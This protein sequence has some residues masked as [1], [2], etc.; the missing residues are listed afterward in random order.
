MLSDDSL[1][2]IILAGGFGKRSKDPAK[3]KILQQINN[4]SLLSRHLENISRIGPARVIFVLHHG[5]QAVEEELIRLAPTFSNLEVHTTRDDGKGV[6]PALLEGLK[7]CKKRYMGLVLGDTWIQA[8]LKQMVDSWL[9]SGKSGGIVARVSDH[10]YDSDALLL[11]HKLEILGFSPKGEMPAVP[12]HVFGMT[13]VAFFDTSSLSGA[14]LQ[15]TDA[16]PTAVSA[17]GLPA[18]EFIPAL[19]Q[20]KDTGT[21]ERLGRAEQLEE[22][23]N[24]SDGA[25]ERRGA[26]FLDRDDTLIPDIPE[27]RH[28]VSPHDFNSDL[29]SALA[30]AS[31]QGIPIHLVSNQPAIAKGWV[32]F[33]TTYHVHNQLASELLAKGV[34]LATMQFC[35]HHPEKGHPGELRELKI[36]CD[37]RKPLPGMFKN[38]RRASSVEFAQSIMV[39][40][41]AAD[42]QVARN[43][44]MPF[45]RVSFDDRKAKLT[46]LEAWI[47]SY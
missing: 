4:R 6:V 22:K 43:L 39:G 32:S 17:L 27:G 34:T 41:S 9:G 3:P 1:D 28:S 31:N 7:L 21:P 38:V 8:N 10:I 16:I 36:I 29:V 26:I 24:P 30:K 14:V 20:F 23:Y 11:D 2:W 19:G 37:C 35:P 42:E 13:G 46:E 33:E 18:C 15:G 25:A 40:D 47:D 5:A 12:A 44:G 45:Q